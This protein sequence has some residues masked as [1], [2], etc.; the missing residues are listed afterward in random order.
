MEEAR[1]L[2]PSS[3]QYTDG[4]DSAIEG[5]DAIVLLTEWNQYRGLD[6]AHVKELMRGDVF[7]HLRNAYEPELMEQH[8]CKYSCIGRG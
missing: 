4:I 3:I 2:L 7:V 1:P 6:L 5:A 8:G